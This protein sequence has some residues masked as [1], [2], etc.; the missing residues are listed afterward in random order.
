MIVHDEIGPPMRRHG[1]PITSRDG[2]G[3]LTD[4]PPAVTVGCGLAGGVALVEL[5]VGAA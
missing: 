2:P 1:I 5:G 3:E 4:F